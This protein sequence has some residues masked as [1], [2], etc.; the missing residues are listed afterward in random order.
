MLLATYGF[1]GL[2]GAALPT[3]GLV[4]PFEPAASVSVGLGAYLVGTLLS[5]S[6]VFLKASIVSALLFLA[7]L[8][9]SSIPAALFALGGAMLAVAVA[10]AFGA[11]SDLVTQ[12]LLGFSPVLTAIALGV[13]FRKPSLLTT[14]YAALGSSLRSSRRRPSTSRYVPLPFLR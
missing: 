5:I 9:V 8:A 10:H 2:S 14:L 13:T 7:G 4:A 3:A 11:E 12:G 1:A 6:Q